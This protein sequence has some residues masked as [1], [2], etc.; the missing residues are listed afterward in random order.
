MFMR[1]GLETGLVE[2][3]QFKFLKFTIADLCRNLCLGTRDQPHRKQEMFPRH[4]TVGPQGDG[5]QGDGPA[6]LCRYP[7]MVIRHPS[8]GTQ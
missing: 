6:K 3:R 4:V 8:E 2:A 1:R 7:V 5:P